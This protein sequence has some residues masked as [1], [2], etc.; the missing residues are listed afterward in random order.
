MNWCIVWNLKTIK[1]DL[2]YFQNAT[3][4]GIRTAASSDPE[5]TYVIIHLVESGRPNGKC[6]VL[7]LAKPWLAIIIIVI[8]I[9]TLRPWPRFHP[10]FCTKESYL[11]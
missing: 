4:Q 8:I 11:P 1:P 3:L 10:Q 5:Q 2:S 6:A 9:I 7:P